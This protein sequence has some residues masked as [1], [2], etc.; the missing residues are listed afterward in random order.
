[1]R[2]L[3]I[4]GRLSPANVALLRACRGLGVSAQLLPPDVAAARTTDGAA[5]L[6]RVD[7]LPSIDGIEPGLDDLRALARRGVIVLNGADSLRAAHDKRR[8]ARL[9]EA[10]ALPHPRTWPVSPGGPLPDVDGPVVVK[11]RFG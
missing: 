1:M 8:T 6:G 7:V 9:L 10:A 11:P 4:A 3:V 2:P 5:V